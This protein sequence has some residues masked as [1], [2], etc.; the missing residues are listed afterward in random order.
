MNRLFRLDNPVWTFISKA[1]DLVLLSLLWL[2]FSLPVI[3]AGPAWAALYHTVHTVVL[4]DRGHLLPTFWRSFRTNLG[5]GMALTLACLPAAAF[6]GV[7]W[8]FAGAMGK[9]SFLGVFYRIVALAAAFLLCA[10]TLYLFPMLS[11]FY[12]KNLELLKAAMALAVTRLGFTAILVALAVASALAIYMVPVSSLFLPGLTALAAERL[13]EPA[14][15]R[16]RKAARK[17]GTVRD[18]ENKEEIS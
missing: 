18:G 2:L 10:G 9:E 17:A 8:L 12:M 1:C 7:S 16:A 3:T 14:I 6:V 5:Q 4:E 13:I 15:R 11:R